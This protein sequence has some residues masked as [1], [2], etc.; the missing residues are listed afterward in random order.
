M[1]T[2]DK[3]ALG[4]AFATGV[5]SLV[6]M[7]GVIV[8][9]RQLRRMVE[10]NSTMAE[11]NKLANAMAVVAIEEAI[12]SARA[13]L[14]AA[15]MAVLRKKSAPDQDYEIERLSLE[16]K[17]ERYLNVLDRLCS[18]IRRGYIDEETYRQDY[19]RGIAETI[20][21][22]RDKFGP[23]TRHPNVLHVNDAWRRDRSARDRPL[24]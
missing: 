11:A 3:I 21:Q 12:R 1:T 7:V 24:S 16:E 4:G 15:A 22:H 6:S 8:V 23:D 18:Y 17:T 9:Y 2:G 10:A 13:E 14:A 19:R 20:E 5:G